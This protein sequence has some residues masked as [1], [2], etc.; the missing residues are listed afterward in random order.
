M[1][2]D[3]AIQQQTDPNGQAL[4]TTNERQVVL[5]RLYELIVERMIGS[6]EFC[7]R[8]VRW[9]ADLATRVESQAYEKSRGVRVNNI[10]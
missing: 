7:F 5:Q 2:M 6:H 8:R 3:T 1:M 4:I 10:D 9:P